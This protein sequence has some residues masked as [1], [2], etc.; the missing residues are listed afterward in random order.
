MKAKIKDLISLEIEE[1]LEKYFPIDPNGFGTRV[2]MMI[3]PEND[4][5]SESF[6]IF[7][8]PQHGLIKN[9]LSVRFSGVPIC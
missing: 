8:V 6:D 2:R 9:I 1:S 3:G 5:G 4:T 7:Y